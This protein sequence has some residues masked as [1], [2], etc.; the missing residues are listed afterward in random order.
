MRNKKQHRLRHR[1][2]ENA[3]SHSNRTAAADEPHRSRHNHHHTHHRH[4]RD[5]DSRESDVQHT[6]PALVLQFHGLNDECARFMNHTGFLDAAE[7]E[8]FVV[9][10]ACGTTGLLGVAWNAGT[11]CGFLH[12]GPHDVE[13]AHIIVDTLMHGR[14]VPARAG[15]AHALTAVSAA[16]TPDETS[17][18][19]TASRKAW[20]HMRRMFSPSHGMRRM[21]DAQRRPSAGKRS[22]DEQRQRAQAGLLLAIDPT[23][24]MAMGFSNGGMLAEVL[25]CTAPS[26]F[27]AV[28]SISGVVEMVPGNAAGLRACD[29]AMV[30]NTSEGHN[31]SQRP[32]VLMV[33]GDADVMVPWGG[34]RL[35]GFP[36]MPDNVAGWA[37]RNN[38]TGEPRVTINT[39]SFVNSRYA[40]CAV[41][42]AANESAAV[43]PP[44]GYHTDAVDRPAGPTSTVEVVRVR[45]GHHQ[46]YETDEFST[47]QYILQ[48]GR[49]A[50]GHY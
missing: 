10:S 31:T 25:G 2:H 12:G 17:G 13:F 21:I 39:T 50:F 33:H 22:R 26:R 44:H 28:V 1:D 30:A 34:N 16:V 42:S 14:V 20:Q 41:V 40:D 37:R 46:W 45:G 49:R 7:R 36:P 19:S 32:S 35:L 5:D 15:T 38:C 4:H 9:A 43:P 3:R 8:G 29:A 23:R 47:E 27:A 24:V 6:L 18:H 11:C 48:F